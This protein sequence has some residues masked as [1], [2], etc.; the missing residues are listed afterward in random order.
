MICYAISAFISG[1][2]YSSISFAFIRV[3]SRLFVSRFA[4]GSAVIQGMS[5]QALDGAG[6]KALGGIAETALRAWPG[7]TRPRLVP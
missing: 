4:H 1:S 2:P 5:V 7:E 6:A 3:H